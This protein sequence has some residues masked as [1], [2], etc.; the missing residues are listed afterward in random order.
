MIVLQPRRVAARSTARRMAEERGTALGE[1]VGYQIRFE[2]RSSA[3]TRILVVTEGVLIRRLLDDP[4][5]EGVGAIVLDE[6]H[7]RHLDTDLALAMVR[8]VQQT[9]RPDLK[10]VVMSATLSVEPL[11]RY[12]ED[13]AVVQ[14]E[15]RQHPVDILYSEPVDPRQLPQQ[16]AKGLIRLAELTQ[17]HLLAFLPGVGEIQRTL[18]ALDDRTAASWGEILPL[19]GDLSSQEQDRVFQETGRRKVILATNIA[20]TSLT[21]PGVTGVVDSGW[22]RVP[23]FDAATGLN[24]LVLRPISK[25]SAIQRAGRAGRTGPG[26]CLRLWSEA[27]QR[28]R[29]E[30][31]TP[32]LHRVDLAG[33]VLQLQVWGETDCRAFP[34]F[35][36][37]REA[38][39]VQAETL[40]QSL[41]AIDQLG[42]TALGQQLVTLPIH[43][44]LARLILCGAQAGY[45]HEAV[46]A[47]VL[48]SERDPFTAQNFRARA[49]HTSSSDVIDRVDCLLEHERTGRDT[50]P[51]GQ[52]HRDGTRRLFQT[53]EQL[54][55]LV[56][57]DSPRGTAT[58]GRRAR[59]PIAEALGQAILLAFPD[60]LTRRREPQSPR[61]L[62]V[63][64]RGV[65]LAEN[66]AVREAE[67]FI[68]VV[69]E[70]SGEEAL[71]RSASAVERRWLPEGQLQTRTQVVFEDGPRRVSARKRVEWYGLVLE[72][73]PAPLPGDDLVVPV[74]SEAAVQEWD[75]VYPPDDPEVACYVARVQSLREW[76]PEL[77]LPRWDAAALQELLPFVALG[78]RSFVDLRRAPWLHVLK[79]QLSFDQLQAI[80]CE[81]PERILV[82]SGSRVAIT[83]EPGQPPVLPVRIQEIFGWRETPRVA[84]G[85]VKLLLHLLAPNHRPQQ[86][87]D[88]LASFWKTAYQQVRGELRRRYPRHAWPEDP[89]T[90]QAEKRPQR[91]S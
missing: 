48:L 66:S 47:A 34:W 19:Y 71:V 4:F 74:L 75:R 26:Y 68:S 58:A 69:V 86:I 41:G 91:K 82:P 81:A 6:F 28:T 50:F 78:C 63:G 42:V 12:L 36:P 2:R 77:E 54:E 23:E 22:A 90:A 1:E 51:L 33:V 11:Q 7:E 76:L 89:W 55:R 40:L 35:E 52:L 46:L 39:L 88:D 64:G 16:V 3:R 87:T 10:L 56:Q 85:R 30:F 80:E 84:R 37:P 72:E 45:P 61:G 53:A 20:E 67:F 73:S 21:I 17:G 5:L 15:V 44:R 25:A 27:Q 59:I 79:N 60:R 65:N 18:A 70:G 13:P 24:R 38:A 14:C 62:M 8:R 83:Y 32:E 49:T 29:S 31:E 57:R 9:V 43:P